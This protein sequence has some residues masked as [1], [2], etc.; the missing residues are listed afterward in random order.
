MSTADIREK[1]HSY[2]E[3]AKD[4]KVKA[5]FAMVEEEIEETGSHW[6]DETFL[7][8][9]NKREKKYLAGKTK[10]YS[11]D[12]IVSRAKQSIKSKKGK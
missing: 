2:I 4:K 7:A 1:L 6:K 12:D 9:L 11:V 5:I 3:T 10:A 8:E